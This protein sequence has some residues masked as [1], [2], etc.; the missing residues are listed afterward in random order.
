M[1]YFLSQVY[2]IIEIT[3]GIGYEKKVEVVNDNNTTNIN[4]TNNHLWPEITGTYKM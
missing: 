4:K 3:F 1:F 2:L